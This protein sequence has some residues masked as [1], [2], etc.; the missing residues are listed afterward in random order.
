M[1]VFWVHASN[2]ARF[3]Q[4]YQEIASLVK[5]PDRKNP[6]ANIFKLVHDWL[7]YETQR[8]WVLVLDNVDNAEFLTEPYPMVQKNDDKPHNS[9]RLLDYI[10]QSPNGSILITTRTRSAALRLVEE[11]EIIPVDPMSEA[12][13]IT[14]LEKK[15][16]PQAN[17]EDLAALAQELEFMP[18]AIVQAAGY[19]AARAPR[20]SIQQYISKLQKSDKER[21]ILLNHEGG[22]LRR[23]REAKNSII[24]TWQ[25]SF[26]HIRDTR[27]SA[28][29]L[30]SLMSFFDRQGIPEALL[31][32][33]SVIDGAG[34][35]PQQAHENHNEEQDNDDDKDDSKST[36]SVNEK[37]EDDILILKGYSFISINM[38]TSTFGMHRLVQLSMRTWLAAHGQL[39]P[40]RR[41]F[42]RNLGSEFP[43]LGEHENWKICEALF[44]HAK[45][46]IEQQ[47][48]G[49]VPVL[50][51][52]S[53]VYSAAWYAY[54]RGRVA[55]ATEMA[56]KSMEAR[57]ERLGPE[58]VRTL[59]STEILILAYQLAGRWQAVEEMQVQLVETSKR[60]LG[61]DHLLT[62]R[63]MNN[64]I[65]IFLSQ[66]RHKEAEELGLQ[67]VELK[68]RVLGLEHRE[69][70]TGMRNLAS[71]YQCQPDRWKEAEELMVQVVE[72]SK[73]VLGPE[74]PDTLISIGNLA[75]SYSGQGRLKE[76]EELT[77]QIVGISERI[78]GPEHPDTLIHIGNLALS[79]CAQ[80]R[81]KEAE[82]LM[83]QVM[84][85]GKRVLGPEHPQILTSIG[86]LAFS[87][88]MQGR[89]KEAEELELRVM[90]TRKR[91]LGQEHP[92][93][94]IA[95]ENL[96]CTLKGQ[97]RYVE[98]INL[99]AECAQL[100]IRVLG[101][102]DPRS[103]RYRTILAEWARL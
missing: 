58:H 9:L 68:S 26:D 44:P 55:D 69:T 75:L 70:L 52:A 41:R 88:C 33:Q 64:L 86:N 92:S 85:I 89:L 77:V 57:E 2:S 29:D 59:E 1:W 78:L 67:V 39:E 6:H 65:E 48:Q 16:G 76:A 80:G 95:V 60:V 40:W 38:D 79:Y 23:D 10:P 32:D 83:V 20:C 13:T 82:E 49:E 14:L 91:V 56:I 25:I 94:L 93:T 27:P 37:F 12:D 102:D 74:H 54:R 45:V 84:E 66:G 62:M 87:Y 50:E 35:H 19:I 15:L 53:L 90:E 34:P 46:A 17:R 100:R 28:A 18:L 7:Y 21:T 73:R 43:I 22:H 51:W 72:I 81:L 97:G 4:G 31:R 5:L 36:S 71:V 103:I 47:P 8:R 101:A 11:T 96:A 98:A 61:L 24:I 63:S 30:L 42:I 99:M 3:E